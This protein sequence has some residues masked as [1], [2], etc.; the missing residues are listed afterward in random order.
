MID[1]QEPTESAKRVL[2]VEDEPDIAA[3]V[4]ADQQGLEQVLKNLIENAIRYSSPGG[5]I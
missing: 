4:V 1:S 3:L 2:V 5:T